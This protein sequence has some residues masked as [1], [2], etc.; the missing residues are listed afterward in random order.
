MTRLLT[1]REVCRLIRRSPGWFATHKDQLEGHGFP[2]PVSVIG[3]YDE[4]AIERWLDGQG[5]AAPARDESDPPRS[6]WSA[7]LRRVQQS[8][9][10]H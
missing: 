4:R 8:N 2:K 7:R 9:H 6:A 1:I 5:D 10:A 3:H